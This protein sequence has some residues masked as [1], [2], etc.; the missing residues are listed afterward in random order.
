[1]SAYGRRVT[2]SRNVTLTSCGLPP[3]RVGSAVMARHLPPRLRSPRTRALRGLF[4]AL[5]AIAGTPAL[6]MA[7]HKSPKT[8]ASVPNCEHFS[9]VKMAQLIHVGS[10]EF[11]GKTPGGNICEWKSAHVHGHYSD[12]LEVDVTAESKALF[13]R[14]ERTLLAHV[15][16]ALR[17]H[18]ALKAVGAELGFEVEQEVLAAGL[19]PCEPEFTV[20][21]LGPPGCSGAPDWETNELYLYGALK[22]RGP[23]AFVSV[24]LDGEIHGGFIDVLRLGRAILSGQIR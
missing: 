7:S 4:F 10:L 1:M 19:G 22:P 24:G 15:K 23:K 8:P 12:L 3:K 5:L 11:E 13:V 6:A 14:T 17:L 9:R 21:E 2:F 16:G 20:P 18:E